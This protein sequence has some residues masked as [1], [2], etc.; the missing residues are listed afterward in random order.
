MSMTGRLLMLGCALYAS[1]C[2]VLFK[3]RLYSGPRKARE[4]VGVLAN[5]DQGVA[6]DVVMGPIDGDDNCSNKLVEL[7]PGDHVVVLRYGGSVKYRL[8]PPV[9]MQVQIQAGH[10][11]VA[12][13]T[14]EG[15]DPDKEWVAHINDVTDEINSDQ[16]QSVRSAIEEHWR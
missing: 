10:T 7:L 11:Y 9:A 1:A 12:F 4:E 2:G 8:S 3:T 6:K 5:K 16:W 15:T 14:E 13:G